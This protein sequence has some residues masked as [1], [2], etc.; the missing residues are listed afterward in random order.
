MTDTIAVTLPSPET[1]KIIYL[2][3]DGVL[4]DFVGAACRLLG[5]EEPRW[6]GLDYCLASKLGMDP[7]TFCSELVYREPKFWE[8]IDPYPW[9]DELIQEAM[10]FERVAVVTSPAGDPECYSGKFNWLKQH[11]PESVSHSYSAKVS[12]V[13][14]CQKDLM[15]PDGV[16]VDDSIDNIERFEKAGGTGI[17]FPRPWN[18]RHAIRRSV[19]ALF[20]T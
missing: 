3:M 13:L 20:K 16:L 10:K 5:V 7:A 8:T 6:D 12:H 11:F 14:C 4:C 17:L 1:H 19:S 18:I 9:K 15:R 2:D